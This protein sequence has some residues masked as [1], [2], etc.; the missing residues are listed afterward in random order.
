MEETLS[1]FKVTPVMNGA[2]MFCQRSKRPCVK[3]IVHTEM[4]R[5]DV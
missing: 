2:T 3:A 1:R 4:E 5:E